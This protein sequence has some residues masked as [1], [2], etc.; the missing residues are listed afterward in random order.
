MKTAIMIKI[1][2]CDKIKGQLFETSAN[3]LNDFI[4]GMV[5]LG[6]KNFT[7]TSSGFFESDE[8]YCIIN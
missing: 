3:S 6:Y 4:G 1:V 5:R 2:V 7:V 8:Y